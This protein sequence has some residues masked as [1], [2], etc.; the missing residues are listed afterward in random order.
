MQSGASDYIEVYDRIEIVYVTR[1]VVVAIRRGRRKGFA[2]RDPADARKTRSEE[3]IGSSLDQLRDPGVSGTAIR[4]V[5]FEAAILRR[6]VRWR[7]HDAICQP[8]GPS[9]VVLQDCVRERRR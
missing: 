2:Q 5:V 8:C 3:A 1:N 4:R 6:V 9:L 7:D